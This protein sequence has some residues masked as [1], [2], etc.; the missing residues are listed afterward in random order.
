[1]YYPHYRPPPTSPHVF[2]SPEP[3]PPHLENIVISAH[4]LFD[5]SSEREPICVDKGFNS[6][7]FNITNF[8]KDES[9]VEAIE[10]E[11]KLA[12]NLMIRL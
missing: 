9:S 4:Q 5:I 8:T 6:E 11:N 3:H 7:V 2:H 10:I 12:K 1:M